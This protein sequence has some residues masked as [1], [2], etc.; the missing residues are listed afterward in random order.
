VKLPSLNFSKYDFRIKAGGQKNLIFDKIRKKF[1]TLTPEE[2]VR[3][4]VIE[5]LIIEKKIS[6]A[7][8]AVEYGLNW[9]GMKHRCDI[10]VFDEDFKPRLIVECKAISIPIS[11]SVFDQIARYN[12][13]MKVPHLMVTNGMQHIYAKVNFEENAVRFTKELFGE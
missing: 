8:I 12:I 6:N 13:S 3:Q 10:V 7:K 11:Q 2:W 5:F 9:N 1:V 4:H